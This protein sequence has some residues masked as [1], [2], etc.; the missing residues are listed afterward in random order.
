[1][2]T[3]EVTPDGLIFGPNKSGRKYISL[4]YHRG[5]GDNRHKS[6]WTIK[7]DEEYGIFCDG[8]E[9]NWQ[10]P[11][12]KGP[13]WGIFNHG[14]TEVGSEEERLCKFPYNEN[15]KNPWH[16]FPFSTR[17]AQGPVPSFHFI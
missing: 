13:Y 2:F 1:M 15:S 16:G 12:D 14:L 7:H 4:N 8:D 9:G 3:R 17:K 11:N 6:I 5:S 10:D